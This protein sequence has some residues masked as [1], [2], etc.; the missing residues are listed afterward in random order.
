MKME[1]TA[2]EANMGTVIGDLSSRRAKILG[3]QNV[4]IQ[5][6]LPQMGR[7]QSFRAMRR[8]LGHSLRDVASSIWNR[9]TT[10]RYPRQFN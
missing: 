4:E 8:R 9:P 5:L 1:V 2:P 7:L 6:L 10:K 3:T